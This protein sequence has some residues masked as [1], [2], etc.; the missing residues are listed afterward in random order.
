MDLF[1][2]PLLFAISPSFTIVT[3]EAGISIIVTVLGP[4]TPFVVLPK[5]EYVDATGPS[6]GLTTFGAAVLVHVELIVEGPEL[7]THPF[8]EHSVP[9]GQHPPP[10]SSEHC[11][12]AGRQRGGA[13][14]ADWQS[15]IGA[16][17]LQ[18]IMF[19]GVNGVG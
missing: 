4:K 14:S 16:V 10:V 9:L 18:H 6:I 13:A 2:S 8:E 1:A 17:E 19:D 5:V 12:V 15:E 7:C 11:S 3:V